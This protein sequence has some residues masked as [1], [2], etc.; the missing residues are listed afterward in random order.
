MNSSEHPL[1]RTHY[2]IRHR[3][4]NKNSPDY[5]KYGA[6]GITFHPEW[7]RDINAFAAYMGEKP[8]PAHSVDR[9]PDKHG[10]YVPGNVR[11]ATPKQQAN[12]RRADRPREKKMTISKKNRAAYQA[13]LK[14]FRKSL[15]A[16][17]AGVTRQALTKWEQVPLSRVNA[18]SQKTGIPPE[19]ILPEPYA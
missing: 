10:S 5:W 13:L 11:W 6:K 19:E 4:T 7:D 9:Y 2:L 1:Y 3:C 18:I 14:K 8:S 15:L 17:L 12:N 16:D